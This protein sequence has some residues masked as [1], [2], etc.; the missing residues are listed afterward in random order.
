LFPKTRQ[1][2][3]DLSRGLDD[4]RKWAI[5]AGNGVRVLNLA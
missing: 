5:P 1:Y 2:I 3:D 4:D